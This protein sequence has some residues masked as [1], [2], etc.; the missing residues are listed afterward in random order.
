MAKS[1]NSEFS[2]SIDQLHESGVILSLK[3]SNNNIAVAIKDSGQ[4]VDSNAVTIAS[5]LEQE[6]NTNL[7]IVHIKPVVIK[8]DYS[9]TPSYSVLYE[10]SAGEKEPS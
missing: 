9:G 1:K 4:G 6:L 5:L 3:K 2:L 8:G 10:I 7:R